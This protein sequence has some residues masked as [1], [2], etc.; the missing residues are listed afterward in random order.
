MDEH[1]DLPEMSDR[2]LDD[3]VEGIA[4]EEV[5]RKPEQT[6][7]SRGV[8]RRRRPRKG[9]RTRR[10]AGASD[11]DDGPF[12]AKVLAYPVAEH[13][14]RSGQQADPAIVAHAPHPRDRG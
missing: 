8:E 12:V 10:Q 4:I 1:V 13:T 2:A 11:G 6:W 7:A 5:H 14:A 3:G 9:H